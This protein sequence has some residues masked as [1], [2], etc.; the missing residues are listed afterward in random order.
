MDLGDLFL[1]L[2]L[3]GVVFGLGSASIGDIVFLR[4][5]RAG[6]ITRENFATIEVVGRLVWVGLG[7]LILSGIGLVWYHFANIPDW[8]IPAKLWAKLTLVLVITANGLLIHSR[9]LPLIHASLDQPLEMTPL[10]RSLRLAGTSGAISLTSWWVTFVLGGFRSLDLDYGTIMAIYAML[11]VGAMGTS[12]L[13]LPRLIPAS[14][15][16]T[17]V[18][19]A[20][21]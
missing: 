16:P 14:P 1:I 5:L 6:R 13:L 9:I 10:G 7:I 12:W 17:K 15:T 3:V 19:T 2:H 20:T 8:V 11:L 21:S 18:R 4:A